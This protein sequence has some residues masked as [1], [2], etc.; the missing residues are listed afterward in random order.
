MMKTGSTELKM[1]TELKITGQTWLKE[2]AKT[3]ARTELKTAMT[4]LKTA[5]ILNFLHPLRRY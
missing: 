4:E 5:S 2:T 3:A 1:K